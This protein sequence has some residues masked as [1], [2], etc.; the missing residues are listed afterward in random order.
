MVKGEF[1]QP[2]CADLRLVL[3]S[4]QGG[5]STSDNPDR[6]ATD[7]PSAKRQ[8]AGLSLDGDDACSFYTHQVVIASKSPVIRAMLVRA[9]EQRELH[10]MGDG[11]SIR[12][13]PVECIGA[14]CLL[15]SPLTRQ[16]ADL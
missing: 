12:L 5:T 2:T 3:R 4:S 16:P 10:T 1:N 9:K 13:L 8:C 6:T 11:L 14:V 7:S 15:V